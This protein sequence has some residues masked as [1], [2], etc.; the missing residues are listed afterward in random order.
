MTIIY[1]RAWG[2]RFWLWLKVR[3]L[4]GNRRRDWF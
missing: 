2:R 3:R 1:M 4:A